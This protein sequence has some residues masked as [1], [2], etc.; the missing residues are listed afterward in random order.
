MGTLALVEAYGMTKSPLLK[1][2]AQSALD[3]SAAARNPYFGWRYGV[4]PGDN[5]TS[6][7]HWMLLGIHVARGINEQAVKDGRTAPLVI[8]DAAFDGA[9]AWVEKMTDPEFGRVGY[10]VR[11]QGVA[12]P[13][14]LV[15][16]F[17]SE[18]SEA[19]TAAGLH[20][21]LMAGQDV[22]TSEPVGKGIELMLGTPPA[23]NADDGSIDM[24]YWTIGTAVMTQVG[25]RSWRA[26]SAR[27]L[28][29]VVPRQRMDSDVCGAKGSFDPIG[30]WGLDG[31]RVYST[32]MMAISLGMA[33]SAERAGER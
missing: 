22:E 31:G 19:M 21:R 3:F 11:G 33:L 30:P 5:D 14:A 24:Y 16:R 25:G 23:W 10:I 1:A 8:D 27:L 6:I 26:W 12:R 9:L 17:P 7:T 4:R 2:A 20:I 29:A 28:D 32:A 15:D 13:Q 18:Q